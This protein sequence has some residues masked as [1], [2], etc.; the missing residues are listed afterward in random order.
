MNV[1]ICIAVDTKLTYNIIWEMKQSLNVLYFSHKEVCCTAGR[2]DMRIKIFKLARK[3]FR[4][5]LYGLI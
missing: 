3:K 5:V 4:S 2:S 1:C